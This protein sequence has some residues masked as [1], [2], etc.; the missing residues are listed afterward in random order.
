MGAFFLNLS[1]PPYFLGCWE[2]G[3]V[4]IGVLFVFPSF[5]RTQDKAILE[6]AY[7]ANPKPDKAARLDIV[8]R[9]SLNEKEVQVC[10]IAA[11]DVRGRVYMSTSRAV[12]KK[13][14]R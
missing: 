13:N 12:Q 14:W 8:K 1:D 9:V 5:Y 4:D 6:A 7:N 11:L 10:I 2:S 3:L